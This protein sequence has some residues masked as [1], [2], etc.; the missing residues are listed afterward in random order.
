V[1]LWNLATRTEIKAPPQN[2]VRFGQ[3]TCALWLYRPNENDEILCYGTSLGYTVFWGKKPGNKGPDAFCEMYTQRCA[4]KEIMCMTTRSS[5]ADDT[6]LVVG[7]RDLI[8]QVWKVGSVVENVFSVKLSKTVPSAVAF[9]ENGKDII[10]F[11]REDG[12]VYV[13]IL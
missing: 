4:E 8:I 10:L 2:H 11:G 1:R 9:A 7:T 12:I 3:V 13:W 6:R 5:G